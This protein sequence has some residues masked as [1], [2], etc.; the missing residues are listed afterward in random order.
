[1]GWIHVWPMMALKYEGLSIIVKGIRVMKGSIAMGNT[2]SLSK[3][4]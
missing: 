2:T 3:D 4:V 1:M